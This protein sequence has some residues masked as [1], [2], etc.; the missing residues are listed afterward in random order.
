MKKILFLFI[1]ITCQIFVFA[2]DERLAQQYFN[3]G[4]FEK[5]AEL[6]DKLYKQNANS[7]YFNQLYASLLNINKY[8]EAEKIIKK[9]IKDFPREV[10]LYVR[11]GTLFEKQNLMPKAEEQYKKAIENLTNNGSLIHQ[12]ANDFLGAAKY[13]YAIQAYQKG[14]KLVKI[15]N[16]FA[17]EIANIYR[18]KGDTQDM[19]DQYLYSIAE[20]P[21]RLP[22]VQALLQRYLNPS[23]FDL[24]QKL[25]YE[26]IQ[27]D[28]NNTN[29]VELLVWVFTQKKD[30]AA[31]FKQV[32][33]LDRRLKE[34]GS[35]IYKLAQEAYMENEYDAAIEAF[36]YIVQ[37]KG[38]TCPYYVEAKGS[39]LDC[40]RTRIT[41]GFKY[42][43]EDLKSLE[44]DYESFLSEF[45]K[46][47]NSIEI[48]K[49][50]A[51]LEAYYMHDLNKAI[52]LLNEAINMPNLPPVK[53][54][55]LK[56][57]LGDYYLMSGDM[58]ESTLLYS[59]VDKAM[60][61]EPIAE[62]ARYKNAKLSYYKG[63]FE[64]AQA[65]LEILKGATS[66]LISNDAIDVNVF[67]MENLNLDT[68]TTAMSKFAQADLLRFQNKFEESI[69]LMDSIVVQFPKHELED[70]VYYAKGQIYLQKR[71]IPQALSFFEKLVKEKKES[72]LVDNAL[73][74]MAETYEHQLKDP[75]KA[76]ELYQ[77]IIVDHSSSTFVIEARKRYR[78]LRGDNV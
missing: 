61:D 44:Q 22:N 74:I 8:E 14:T 11:Y 54:S 7:H 60:K 19:I 55:E 32:K 28:E 30:Y 29:Y 9:R 38:N 68:S 73:F 4:E 3:N 62:L 50:L 34:N 69:L 12:L 53:L 10:D 33:A 18:L 35:R 1:F 52:S 48:I 13:D 42:T 64:W 72:I 5:S 59:Q 46:N 15:D 31:A 77:Q 66:E 27:K 24:L 16:Y 23:D 26:R 63:D 65:Q 58:W 39:L 43:K 51:Y 36:S 76:M 71:D 56:L 70:N 41:T 78:R 67:I 21:E 2:Q 20:I 47:R 45:G 49:E 40:K 6:Y 17:Y 37:E 75:K 57:D 25:L